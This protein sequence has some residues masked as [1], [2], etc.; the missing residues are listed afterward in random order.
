M[1]KDDNWPV[2]IAGPEDEFGYEPGG[3]RRASNVVP[4]SQEKP[5]DLDDEITF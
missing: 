3:V 5:A 4:F 1:L 2:R